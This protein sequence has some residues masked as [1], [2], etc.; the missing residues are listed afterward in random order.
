ML[1]TSSEVYD[2]VISALRAKGHSLEFAMGFV[3]DMRSVP[4]VPAAMTAQI[5][6][7]A[8]SAYVE[9]GGRG[10]LCYFDSFHVATAKSLGLTMLTSDGYILRNAPKLGIA[11]FDIMLWEAEERRSGSWDHP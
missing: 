1:R 3:S 10:R 5:A 11:A 2:D 6:A 7:E 9:F 8:L 4:H